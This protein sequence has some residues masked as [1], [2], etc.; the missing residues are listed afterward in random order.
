M[1]KNNKPLE[2]VQGSYCALPH[3]VLDSIALMGAG[4]TARSLLFDL[5]RQHNGKN[6]GH[7]QMALPWLRKRGWTSNDVIHRAKLELIDRGLIIQTRQ[8]GLSAGANLYAIT[9]LI[10]T[11]FVG[12]DIRPK[13]YHPGAWRLM[14]NLP[15][16]GKCAPQLSSQN[17]K[18][19]DL[20]SAARGDTAPHYGAVDS[21]TVPFNGVK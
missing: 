6:N 1:G 4:H 17:S 5:L 20:R 15:I 11:N 19:Y 16:M 21:P 14:E 12:L 18:K 13:D 3:A 10:I 8:G 7:F 9:W 2:S